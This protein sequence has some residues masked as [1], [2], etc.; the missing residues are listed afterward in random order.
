MAY[1]RIVKRLQIYIEEE[2]DEA[3]GARAAR[4]HTSKAALIRAIVAER[5]AERAG[6]PDPLDAIVGVDAGEPANVDDVVYGPIEEQGRRR[7]PSGS[8]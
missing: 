5:F 7:S 4:E 8:R 3:L 1:T 2:L 6:R